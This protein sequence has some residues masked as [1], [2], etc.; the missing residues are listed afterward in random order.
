VNDLT[1]LL[2]DRTQRNERAGG[3]EPGFLFE[4]A[5]GGGQWLLVIVKFPLGNRPDAVI[6]LAEERAAGVTEKELGFAGGRLTEHQQA[7][8]ALGHRSMITT[9]ERLRNCRQ[10]LPAHER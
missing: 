10:I 1:R 7:G 5:L 4:L 6:L 8:A 9:T 2:R 3:F